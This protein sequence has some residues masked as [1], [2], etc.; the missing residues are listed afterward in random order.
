MGVAA[1]IAL[2]CASAMEMLIKEKSRADL[3]MTVADLRL[4][5][6]RAVLKSQ[7]WAATQSHESNMSCFSG[8][9][10]SSCLTTA[11]LGFQP[12]KVYESGSLFFDSSSSTA[13]YTR[14]GVACS[15]YGTTGDCILKPDLK[16]K[17]ECNLIADPT[18]LSPLIVVDLNFTYSGPS[19]GAINFASYGFRLSKATFP[20]SVG[21]P[22]SGPI[23]AC[24]VSQ[25]AICE[26]SAWVCREFGP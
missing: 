3:L 17:A 12:L 8:T 5:F 19:V 6:Q 10:P 7:D 22:C 15:T 26:S 18:C 2:V 24:T 14:S 11:S 9:L 25:A 1:L 20:L 21:H 13:G 23:P 16:W 4:R